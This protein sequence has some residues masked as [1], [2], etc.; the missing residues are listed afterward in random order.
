MATDNE[1]LQF[2]RAKKKEGTP[3]P[4]GPSDN[5]LMNF[6]RS[7]KPGMDQKVKTWQEKPNTTKIL[8]E[9]FINQFAAAKREAEEG[10]DRAVSRKAGEEV[11]ALAAQGITAESRKAG[12]EVGEIAAQ[13]G[14]DTESFRAGEEVGE[15]AQKG[16]TKVVSEAAAKKR[17]AEPVREADTMLSIVT[18]AF[19]R[20]P[21]AVEKFLINTEAA[22]EMSSGSL[23]I[24]GFPDTQPLY[25]EESDFFTATTSGLVGLAG[26]IPAMVVG[27]IIGGKTGGKAGA[28]AGPK[29]TVVG[30]AAGS[31]IG[32]FGLPAFIR[33]L[34]IDAL[35]K[36]EVQGWDDFWGRV[37]KVAIETGK[38]SGI[39]LATVA[40]GG[41]TTVA[42]ASKSI[43]AAAKSAAV[44]TSEVAAMTAVGAAMEGHAPKPEHFLEALV[45]V[46]VMKGISS[47]LAKRRQLKLTKEE[48]RLNRK[49]MDIYQK[50]GVRPEQIARDIQTNPALKQEFLSKNIE[51]PQKYVR[52]NGFQLI[53]NL[54]QR[55]R[56]KVEADPK[57]V[58]QTRYLERQKGAEGAVVIEPIKLKKSEKLGKLSPDEKAISD[59]IVV[60][61]KKS[62]KFDLD[63][64]WTKLFDDL[65]PIRRA[66]EMAE[67][68]PITQ[69]S[70]G[71]VYQAARNNRG[72]QGVATAFL[73]QGQID[74]ASGKRIGKG[75]KQIMGNIGKQG[76]KFDI[77]ALSRRALERHKQGFEIGGLDVARLKRIVKAGDK[78][79]G[80]VFD[81]ASQFSNNGLKYLKDS[82]VL[83]EKGFNTILEK[84][85]DFMPLHRFMEGQAQGG[86][87]KGMQVF[88]PIKRF[89]GSAKET[90]FISPTLSMVRNTQNNI[91][92][93]ERNRVLQQLVTDLKDV[94]GL[95]KE[96]SNK[97]RPIKV[98][99][100]E[101]RKFLKEEGI[102]P[103]LAKEFTV[104][105]PSMSGLGKNEVAVFF[106]GKRKV[107]ELAPEL[108][109]AVKQ[110]DRGQMNFITRT[111]ALPAK[112]LRAGT[113]LSPE[114]IV[115]NLIR[116]QLV[117]AAVSKNGFVPYVTA[118]EGAFH[119]MR[120]KI[121]GRK[122]S[123]DEVYFDWLKSGGSISSMISIDRNYIKKDIWGLNK[124]TG[125]MDRTHNVLR[126][127]LEILRASSE[128]IENATRLGEFKKA[129]AKALKKGQL[130]RPELI[131]AAFQS[132]NITLDFQRMGAR[133]QGLNQISAFFNA[134]VGGLLRF[135]EAIK[136]RP[137]QTTT[138]MLLTV[139][140]P[141]LLLWYANRGDDPDKPWAPDPD[142]A[143]LPDW[144]KDLFW[145]TKVGDTMVR[146]P[147]PF[148]QGIIFGSAF[149]RSFDAF[150]TDNPEAF[151][152]F[153]ETIIPML[154]P[155]VMPTA[156]VAIHDHIANKSLFTGS[157]IVPMQME[158]LSPELQVV[159]HTSETAQVVSHL[160]SKIGLERGDKFE[161]LLSPIILDHYVRAWT[162]NLGKTL[163]QVT[164][165]ALKATGAVQPKIKPTK[166]L[167]DI[168]GVR[169]FIVRHPTAGTKSMQDFFELH[170]R[171]SEAF[172]NVKFL[173]QLQ[174][175]EPEDVEGGFLGV[176]TARQRFQAEIE[177]GLSEG[178]LARLDGM[179]KSIQQ[180][181]VFIQI[182]NKRQDMTPD[183]KRQQIDQAYTMMVRL[184]RTGVQM[185]KDVE[186]R[187][188]ELKKKRDRLKIKER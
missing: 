25:Q 167:A 4:T 166:T 95:I 79:F 124:Q 187:I 94:P 90:D 3:D 125:F 55:K 17:R 135:S 164:D 5:D 183:E 142:I 23:I 49:M 173:A 114:F 175:F 180:I 66:V 101:F 159:E 53:K 182:L 29:G 117:A 171:N 19:G 13:K 123:F 148:E 27:S 42:L 76:H 176:P 62:F 54:T 112:T 151:K 158:K 152:D 67:G 122:G 9:R 133:T 140:L 60:D 165:E 120:G 26:D 91:L 20:P 51:I 181:N 18:N 137:K 36:G 145:V 106:N 88:N 74:F 100:P 107:F 92:L 68:K 174:A 157:P 185:G 168:P 153:E 61:Q 108:A 126:S 136:E 116:D 186:K 84:S 7:Q 89:K 47:R 169:A 64:V 104:F 40:T 163:V 103:K 73:E 39:G 77:Y 83:S 34:Y 156:A 58:E 170:E 16:L 143:D 128:V 144:Q 70:P 121:K 28:I 179:K 2:F 38:A 37:S 177:L 63:E 35:A 8:R 184:A 21:D 96:I 80:K 87:G 132:R 78:K 155:D 131:D 105:R 59:R 162:G 150:F 97:Q 127:P 52:E 130:G 161:D 44:V 188:K 134:H 56:I 22:L 11:G 99:E 98:T 102:N 147:K 14:L 149:E 72:A 75:F 50:T 45:T 139:T 1:L 41:A 81:E 43:P 154:V 31:G 69:A 178:T 24:S 93:A 10:P 141:S 129:R 146:I 110:L 86:L 33:S 32:M 15:L 57:L 172:N 30:A 111:L 109:G 48:A 118:L 6:Y 85:K 71:N 160:L 138:K 113:T 115:R 46:G 12:K 82:G 119:L 65:H